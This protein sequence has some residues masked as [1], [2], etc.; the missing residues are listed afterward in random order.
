[1]SSI[2]SAGDPNPNDPNDPLH[3]APRAV[4]SKATAPMRPVRLASSRSGFDDMFEETVPRQRRHPLDPEVVYQPNR[5]RARFGVAS[6]LAAAI[7][8]V[9]IIGVIF[10]MIIPKSQGSD[11][12]S[13]GAANA[14]DDSQA[15]LQKFVQFGKSQDNRPAGTAQAPA[16]DSQALLQKF[17][18]WQQ[19]GDSK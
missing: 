19:K 12:T 15:L 11:P 10:F 6:R 5:P 13:A 16:D 14:S 8:V 1:M 9:A 4:R 7:S 2:G 17:M 3:Y 18:Q